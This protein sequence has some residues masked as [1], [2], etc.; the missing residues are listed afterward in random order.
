MR[1]ITSEEH[2]QSVR[3]SG[4]GLVCVC[5]AAR[6]RVSVQGKGKFRDGAPA[7]SQQ[8]IDDGA[9]YWDSAGARKELL[10][11]PRDSRDR[12]DWFRQT[13]TLASMINIINE[14]REEAH[15][16]TVEDPTE[17]YHKHKKAV[18]H[19]ARNRRGRAEFRRG[20]APGLRYILDIILVGEMRDLET[21]EAAITVA[22]TGTWFSALCIRPARPKPLTVSQMRFRPTSRKWCASS[23]RPSCRR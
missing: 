20:V 13:T 21:I 2:I 4:R 19:P 7:D 8:A 3:E 11:K 12:P 10:Y 17:Y 6:F 18:D 1:S 5:E 9:G 22:E 14:E 23:F 16:I 15:I